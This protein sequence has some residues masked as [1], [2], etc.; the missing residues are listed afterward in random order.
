MPVDLLCL[1]LPEE[2][3]ESVLQSLLISCGQLDTIQIMSWGG[4]ELDKCVLQTL[5][6]WVEDFQPDNECMFTDTVAVQ[7]FR[8]DSCGCCG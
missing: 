2:L 8:P 4:D 6:N 1:D 3:C 5:R 7:M